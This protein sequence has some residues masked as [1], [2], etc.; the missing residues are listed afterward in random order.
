MTTDAT[1]LGERR[2][3]VR[4][5]HNNQLL[6][7]LPAKEIETM[8]NIDRYELAWATAEYGV[9]EFEDNDGRNIRCTQTGDQ[10]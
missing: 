6:D 4:Y 10:Q 3:I 8:W 7:I 1:E 9:C 5:A 2:Y